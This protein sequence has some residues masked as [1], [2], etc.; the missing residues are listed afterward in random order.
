MQMDLTRRCITDPEAIDAFQKHWDALL[1]L[2][3]TGS[4]FCSYAWCMAWWRV[5]G[6]GWRPEIHIWER[7][8]RVV[9]VLPLMRRTRFR[10]LREVRYLNGPE[11]APERLD[12]L[13]LEEARA[14][15]EAV[16]APFL[17]GVRRTCDLLQFSDLVPDG[18][19][20][21]ALRATGRAHPERAA[22]MPS[23]GQAGVSITD[24]FDAYFADRG[25]NLRRNY[26]RSCRALQTQFEAVPTSIRPTSPEK[27]LR[28]FEQLWQLHSSSFGR[29]QEFDYFASLRIE[30]F[31]RAVLSCP[32]ILET[33]R[34]V[35]VSSATRVI[36][37][38][39]CFVHGSRMYCY[40]I[41][42]D[43]AAEKLSPGFV[44]IGAAIQTAFDEGCRYV[45]FLRGDESYKQ[46]WANASHQTVGYFE[47]MDTV[48]AR[49]W[50][51][52][53]RG[54]HALRMMKHIVQ[55]AAVWL[56]ATVARRPGPGGDSPGAGQAATTRSPAS[57]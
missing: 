38:M 21:G 40:Q 23:P 20:A 35:T 46:R 29:H 55:G 31:H 56:G 37:S 1:V 27:A 14:E 16:L 15:I 33:V 12:V 43:S 45:D 44:A 48:P 34:F 19:L 42:F 54:I 30:E 6:V 25:F 4:P 57:E 18:P 22:F 41:G 28:C 39:L 52:A 5:F 17:D 47:L 49:M 13:V 36:A 24:T 50:N 2:S 9:A 10:W 7:A 51:G 8:G 3:V 53:T 26:R 32:G 11:V